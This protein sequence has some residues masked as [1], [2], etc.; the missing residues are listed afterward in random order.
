MTFRC[1]TWG[2]NPVLSQKLNFNSSVFST[3]I[4]LFLTVPSTGVW[5]GN[6]VCRYEKWDFIC[7][8]KMNFCRY[9]LICLT[10][11]SQASYWLWFNLRSCFYTALGFCGFFPHRLSW[12]RIRK[13]SLLGQCGQEEQLQ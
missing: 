10:Q 1:K 5:Q 4:S 13:G 11:T 2:S 6:T 8:K 9:H 7:T 3:I 12:N